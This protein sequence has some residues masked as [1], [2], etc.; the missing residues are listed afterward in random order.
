MAESESGLNS[1]I[2][3][4]PNRDGSLDYGIFQV[5]KNV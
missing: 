4:K 3:G 5:R 1:N 2:V